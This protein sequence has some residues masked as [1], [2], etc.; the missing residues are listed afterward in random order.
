[1]I[2][3]LVGVDTVAGQ[4]PES[5]MRSCF[6]LALLL[7]SSWT[8][9]AQS[10]EAI[11]KDSIPVDAKRFEGKIQGI[12]VEFFSNGDPILLKEEEVSD[13]VSNQLT[14]WNQEKAANA[15]RA[16]PDPFANE[17]GLETVPVFLVAVL[18]YRIEG[19]DVPA[20]FRSYRRAIG[21]ASGAELD[22]ALS[23]RGIA[24]ELCAGPV[25]AG[26]G[27]KVVRLRKVVTVE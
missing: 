22:V 7:A 15:S 26:E 14:R 4:F 2:D 9:A 23:E 1:M 3:D 6:T 12:D 16:D 11:L 10:L 19:G 27:A 18:T 24:F 25:P 17:Q 21:I 13:F 20:E 5:F 8:L